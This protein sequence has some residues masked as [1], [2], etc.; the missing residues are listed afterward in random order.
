MSDFFETHGS[1]D[2]ILGRLYGLEDGK[3]FEGVI[4][5]NLSNPIPEWAEHSADRTVVPYNIAT[6]M[7]SPN[8]DIGHTSRPR[9]ARLSSHV[10]PRSVTPCRNR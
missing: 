4:G 3:T 10:S 8:P 1:F 6:D 7:N 2:N 9:T 5:K